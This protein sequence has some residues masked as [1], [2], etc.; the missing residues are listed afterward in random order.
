[1]R[2]DRGAIALILLLGCEAPPERL[3]A[4]AFER[5][6]AGG[7]I[8]ELIHPDYSDPRGDRARLLAEL[9]ALRQEVGRIAITTSELSVLEGPRVIGKLELVIDGRPSWKLVGPLDVELARAG[10]LR[11]RSGF[12]DELRDVRALAAA[13]RA[14]LEGND[15]EGFAAT[16]HPGYR[17][18]DLDKAAAVARFAEDV[19][20]IAI[21]HEPTHY[22]L[23]LRGP[24]AHLDERYTLSVGEQRLENQ[25]AR[26]GLERS[27]GRWLISGGL[28]SR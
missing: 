25:L 1:M 15:P 7:A 22:R 6:A 8:D 26:L 17:D 2:G 23:E 18:G 24:R 28:Y 19:E 27:A 4:T 16:L 12:L 14:A 10:T 3:V 9:S 11:I 21:R 20:G 13:R 5:L